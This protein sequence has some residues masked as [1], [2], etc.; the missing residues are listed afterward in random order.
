MSV[1]HISQDLLIGAD[2]DMSLQSLSREWTGE[3]VTTYRN[4]F[5]Y[6]LGIAIMFF[7]IRK[8][9]PSENVQRAETHK[10]KYYLK[11][12]GVYGRK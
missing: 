10:P 11:L 3:S 12:G 5:Q 6:P 4:I 2:I 7:I 8:M 1:N 9:L